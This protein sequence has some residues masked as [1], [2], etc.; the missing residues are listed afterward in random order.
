MKTG[1]ERG[2][3]GECFINRKKRV[4]QR[5]TVGLFTDGYSVR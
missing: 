1:E 2:G 4:R 5:L 3:L